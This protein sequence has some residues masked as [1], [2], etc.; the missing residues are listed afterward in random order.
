MASHNRHHLWP[1]EA[2]LY[3][4]ALP[5]QRGPSSSVLNASLGS[6]GRNTS[7]VFQEYCCAAE[8]E[9]PIQT[10]A[11]LCFTGQSAW[12]RG[13]D[14]FV[15]LSVC[16]LLS[17]STYIQTKDEADTQSAGH[18][19]KSSS[20][21]AVPCRAALWRGRCWPTRHFTWMLHLT[22]HNSTVFKDSQASLPECTVKSILCGW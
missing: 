13:R 9:P 3:C 18:P 17:F 10:A 4:P 20:R 5:K 22:K 6:I 2:A 19:L 14:V 7:E 21:A 11:V 12:C 16:V 8:Q 1:K 15:C